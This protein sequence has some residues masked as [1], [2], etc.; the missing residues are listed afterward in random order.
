MPEGPPQDLIALVERLELATARQVGRLARR[1]R[2]LARGLP[3]F[4]S[5]WV[6]ALAQAR[7]LTPFQAGEIRAGRGDSLRVGPYVLCRRLPSPGY[8]ECYLAR[9]QDEP[10]QTARLALV[11]SP[12][13]QAAGIVGRLEELAAKCE[14]LNRQHLAPLDRVGVDGN[15]IW[16]AC[17]QVEGQ[18][19]GEWLVRRGRFPPQLVLEIARQMLAGLA[20]LEQ[21][22][23]CHGDISASGLI[24]A[25][26][27]DAVLLYPGLRG[28]LR[29][30]E[31]CAHADLVPEAYDYLAPERIAAGT[32]PSMAGDVYSCGCLWWHLLTG[33]PPVPG[34]SSLEK[35][36][37]AETARI[38]DVSRLAPNTPSSLSAAVSASI[39]R[40][41]GMRPQSMA[42]LGSMLGPPT[43]AGKRALARYLNRAR[44]RPSANSVGCFYVPPTGWPKPS[45]PIRESKPRPAWLAG[46]AGCVVA[47]VA[48]GWSLSHSG[49]TIPAASAP[50]PVFHPI[51]DETAR[52]MG[53][54]ATG[55][56]PVPPAAAQS[57]ANP[58]EEA[59]AE[60]GPDDLVLSAG[61]PLVIESLDARPGQCIRGQPGHR[62]R[63]VVPYGGLLVRAEGVR[64]EN[65][66]FVW[67]HQSPALPSS[68]TQAAVIHVLSARAEFQGCSFR[69]ADTAC[70]RH[71]ASATHRHDASAAR[72]PVA[73][74]WTHPADRSGAELSLYSGRLQLCDCVLDS[75]GGGVACETLGALSVE[76][77]NVL[78]LNAGPL[79]QLDHC[80]KL[81]EP[82]LVGLA[83]V[84]VR[85]AGPL[86]ECRYG[87]IP[88]RPG[89]ISIHADG[90]ALATQPDTPLLSFVGPAW[91]ERI[92]NRIGWTGQGSLVLPEAV[93]AA[94]RKPGGEVQ[95][96]DDA[97]VS[98]AGLVR[99]KVEFAGPAGRGPQA[100]RILRWQVPL[101][102]PNPPGI[103][104]HALAWS[105]RP[106]SQLPRERN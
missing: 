21:A 49:T 38:V 23:L 40:D 17:R 14:S 36:R 9:R 98:I 71:D 100:S 29:P 20:V 4:D 25:E 99:S 11:R 77:A 92:L 80:P 48:V 42:E 10:R 6:D 51:G 3:L 83:N 13:E 96:L 105:E 84:T 52:A 19:A 16:V 82:V 28:I 44:R 61:D 88:D 22:Q 95:M 1:A 75:V 101:R 50:S 94:W 2:R 97:L 34:G 74:R 37:A 104:P 26:Q 62:P 63:V 67:D 81:D 43:R 45:R 72:K 73:V 89:N 85:E 106:A 58:N 64:F 53:P 5:V 79:V 15:R 46:A 91:P 69:T 93:V 57:A 60:N 87:P 31:G 68:E 24:L 30:E 27:A 65:I 76:M 59:A 103:D 78:S 70:H 39:Q 90:C 7:I 12:H 33:R 32:P 102:S 55:I 18:T 47:A 35:L 54:R 41:P 86:L 56:M 66:D 8:L